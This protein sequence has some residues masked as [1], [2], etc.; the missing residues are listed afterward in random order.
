M[1]VWTRSK[2]EFVD[3]VSDWISGRVTRLSVRRVHWIRHVSSRVFS[4]MLTRRNARRIPFR[5]ASIDGT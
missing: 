1:Q 3:S 2:N 4:Q 5:A